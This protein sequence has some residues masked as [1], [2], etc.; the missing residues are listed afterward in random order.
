MNT[1]KK[2]RKFIEYYKDRNVKIPN[3]EHYPRTFKWYVKMYEYEK[4][5]K[6]T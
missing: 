5:R 6:K 1:I 3:P 4:A 2:V